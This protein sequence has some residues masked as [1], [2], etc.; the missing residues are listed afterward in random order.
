M[1]QTYSKPELY[2]HQLKIENLMAI[3]HISVGEGGNHVAET[4][5]VRRILDD[6]D[7]YESASNYSDA[8]SRSPFDIE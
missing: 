4:T 6:D 8:V 7:D 2:I 3:I 1:K 5:T